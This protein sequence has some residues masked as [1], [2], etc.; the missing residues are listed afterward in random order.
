MKDRIVRRLDAAVLYAPSVEMRVYNHRFKRGL[1]TAKE[2]GTVSRSLSVF[3]L[4]RVSGRLP[5]VQRHYHRQIPKVPFRLSRAFSR[6]CA[7]SVL[8]QNP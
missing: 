4:F 2:K 3:R 6:E 5:E 8:L 7:E 1:L